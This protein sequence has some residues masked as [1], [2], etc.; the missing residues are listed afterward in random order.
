MLVNLQVYEVIS[1][2][3]NWGKI[4]DL[5]IFYFMIKE[6]KRECYAINYIWKCVKD[7]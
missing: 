3:N 1:F 4:D 6:N 5:S 2:D 7:C